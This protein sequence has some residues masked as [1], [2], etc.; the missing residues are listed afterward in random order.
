[1]SRRRAPLIAIKA[2]ARLD[3][4]ARVISVP[5]SLVFIPSITNPVFLRDP[6]AVALAEEDNPGSEEPAG[7]QG[8]Q[9]DETR[10]PDHHGYGPARDG[11]APHGADPQYPEDCKARDKQK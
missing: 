11:A 5:A 8:T 6:P 7:D 4:L 9:K 1:M 3:L 2:K 10:L